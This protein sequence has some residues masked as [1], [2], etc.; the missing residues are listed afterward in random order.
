MKVPSRAVRRCRI[1]LCAALPIVAIGAVRAEVAVYFEPGA[2]PSTVAF[3]Q[4]VDGPDP[5]PPTWSPIATAPGRVVLNPL[6]DVNGDGPPSIAGNP[7]RTCLVAWAKSVPGGYDVVASRFADGAWTHPE[8]VA[9]GNDDQIDPF[10][11]ESPDG[12]FHLF[13]TESGATRRV[14]HRTAPADLS[15]WSAAAQVS[16]TGALASRP[17]AVFHEGVL[18]VTYEVDDYGAGSTPRQVAIARLDG[19]AFVT[20]VLAITYSDDPVWPQIHSRGARLWVDWDDSPGQTHW[21]VRDPATGQW[22]PVRVESYSTQ[23]QRLFF[24]RG[25]IQALANE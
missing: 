10:L 17:N 19:G 8:V 13:Y 14:M 12:S 4:I 5:V 25:T 1:A 22:Q 18:R 6:G 7:G 23:L 21:T 11:L 15:S 24:V 9:G 2:R 16:D 3:A 20:E